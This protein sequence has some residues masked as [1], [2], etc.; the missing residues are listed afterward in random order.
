MLLQRSKTSFHLQVENAKKMIDLEKLKP[1]KLIMRK[2]LQFL[3]EFLLT[4]LPF[5]LLFI[6]VGEKPRNSNAMGDLIVFIIGCWAA[7]RFYHKYLYVDVIH[8]ILGWSGV[9]LYFISRLAFGFF[10]LAFGLFKLKVLVYELYQEL[11]VL[12]V[13]EACALIILGLLVSVVFSITVSTQIKQP[14]LKWISLGIC[15]GGG[16]TG[17]CWPIS[18]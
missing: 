1:S 10:I 14:I 5:L 4:C 3:G 2:S 7:K 12:S 17:I 9:T 18:N 8:N 13:S 16:V 6:D 15:F 11:T